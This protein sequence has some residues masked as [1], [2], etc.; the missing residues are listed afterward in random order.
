M[1]Q[2][3]NLLPFSLVLSRH[4]LGNTPFDNPSALQSNATETTSLTTLKAGLL[5]NAMNIRQDADKRAKSLQRR[6]KDDNDL[7]VLTPRWSTAGQHVYIDRPPLKTSCLE[8][9]W[10]WNSKTNWC[11]L[12]WVH[13]NSRSNAKHVNNRRRRNT[14][15]CII[16]RS[17]PSA[18]GENRRVP[19]RIRAKRT[20][21]L[22]DDNGDAREGPTTKDLAEVP[23]ERV[24][25]QNVL[26]FS[27]DAN[28]KYIVL[29]YRY[30]R[31]DCKVELS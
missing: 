15:Y 24:L 3:M 2:P 8:S 14:K 13:S 28:V 12:N 26:P 29:W 22:Q 1:H 10:R 4:T 25:D 19:W 16:L 9:D 30:T 18:I 6:Y 17:K 11:T 23:R 27:K 7:K 21:D 5:H 20:T 31:A